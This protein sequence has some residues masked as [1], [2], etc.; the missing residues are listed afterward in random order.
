[1][2][3]SETVDNIVTLFCLCFNKI[4]SGDIQLYLPFF[5]F[6]DDSPVSLVFEILC[7]YFK[8]HTEIHYS[9]STIQFLQ[10]YLVHF[11]EIP[12]QEKVDAQLFNCLLNRFKSP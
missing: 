1:M 10:K 6:S 8:R 9:E 12:D 4:D 3:S 11:D 5:S 2:F 7:D